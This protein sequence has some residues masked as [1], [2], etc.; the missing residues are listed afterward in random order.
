[1]T[2]SDTGANSSA[3]SQD[4]IAHQ[5]VLPER[6]AKL[7]LLIKAMEMTSSDET[8][9][10]GAK[11]GETIY[12]ICRTTDCLRFMIGCDNCEEWY[13]GDCIGITQLDARTIKRYYCTFCRR[14]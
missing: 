14:I 1:M 7:N 13:H 12:C 4:D 3:N 2:D 8:A 9:P 5:F 6:Q 11:Q 10:Q